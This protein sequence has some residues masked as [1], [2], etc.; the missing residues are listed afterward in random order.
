[1]PQAKTKPPE[2]VEAERAADHEWLELVERATEGDNAGARQI[3][4]AIELE[5]EITRLRARVNSN[6]TY[7]R[8]MNDNNEL[9]DDQSEFVDVFYAEKERGER[10]TDEEAEATQRARRLARQ[11]GKD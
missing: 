11:N 6:R 1:M 7:L 2:S 9:T 5:R 4:R 10:R 3:A 8:L